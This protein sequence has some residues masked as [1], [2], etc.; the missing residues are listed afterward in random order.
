MFIL[1]QIHPFPGMADTYLTGCVWSAGAVR[2][3]TSKEIDKAKTFETRR[4]AIT[5]RGDNLDRF[6]TTKELK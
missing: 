6:W 5:F 3:Q 1:K 4:E 2:P